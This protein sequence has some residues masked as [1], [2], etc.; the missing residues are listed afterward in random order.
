MLACIER[1][2]ALP[3]AYQQAGLS[4]LT[5]VSSVLRQ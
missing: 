5:S 4:L 3:T 2:L 1:S